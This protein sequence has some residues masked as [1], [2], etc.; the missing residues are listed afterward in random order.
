MFDCLSNVW[1][2]VEDKKSKVI[3]LKSILKE[4]FRGRFYEAM[5]RQ[6]SELGA[7]GGQLITVFVQSV[8]K[9]VDEVMEDEK[10]EE[11]GK[12]SRLK[13]VLGKWWNSL[14]DD[15]S[16]KIALREYVPNPAVS[17]WILFHRFEDEWK[18]QFVGQLRSLFGCS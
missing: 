6:A 11:N 5:K 1:E 14:S 18:K 2:M 13:Q 17:P 16:E 4:M 12:L 15:D 7:G 3:I 9:H 10:W 8:K